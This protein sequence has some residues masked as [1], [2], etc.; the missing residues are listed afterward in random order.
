VGIRRRGPPSVAPAAV[1]LG[2]LGA[3][4]VG[5]GFSRLLWL[6]VVLIA[7]A[8]G[9]QFVVMTH[10]GSVIQQV[11]DDDHRGRVMSLYGLCWG[12]L[13]PVGGLLLGVG[14]HFA[15]PLVALVASGLVA[16]AFAALVI[17]RQAGPVQ[18]RAGAA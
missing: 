12:G 7:V 13:L 14:W 15:G 16:I 17:W 2:L 6:E 3:V 8:G 18:T 1:A 9:L 11:V 4:M 10:C 5:L